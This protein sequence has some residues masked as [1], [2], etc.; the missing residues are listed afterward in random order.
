MQGR[1]IATSIFGVLDALDIEPGHAYNILQSMAFSVL[2]EARKD[3]DEAA[4][5]ALDVTRQ[6]IDAMRSTA[7][8]DDMR[9]TLALFVPAPTV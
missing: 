4:L 9:D 2:I 5:R 6:M 8:A 3:D 7:N 1:A